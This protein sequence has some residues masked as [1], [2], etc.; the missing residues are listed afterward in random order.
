MLNSNYSLFG[1]SWIMTQH[2]TACKWRGVL[3]N[4]EFF[5]LFREWFFSSYWFFH[6]YI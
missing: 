5:S 6:I 1:Y 3:I 4:H 2:F